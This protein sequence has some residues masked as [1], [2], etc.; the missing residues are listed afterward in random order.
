ME[1]ADAVRLAEHL[2]PAFLARVSAIV[3]AS[4]IGPIVAGMPVDRVLDVGRRLL[5]DHEVVALARFLGVVDP[6][7]ALQLVDGADGADLLQIALYA[8]DREALDTI[9]QQLPQDR[10][11]ALLEAGSGADAEALVAVAMDL[12]PAA[13]GRLSDA[14]ASLDEPAR[15]TLLGLLD[16]A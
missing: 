12:S 1:P 13:Q 16:R 6:E 15:T 10:I 5:A 8:D 2:S 3:D 14:V 11:R 9:V 4:R 7:V